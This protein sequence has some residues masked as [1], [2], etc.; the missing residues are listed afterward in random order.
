[1]NVQ[2]T[3]NWAAW[4]MEA[5][6]ARFEVKEAPMWTPGEGEVLVRNRAVAVN[7]VDIAVQTL[8]FFSFKYPTILGHDLA[9]EVVEVG[10]GVT[11]YKKGDRVLGQAIGMMTREN[12][13]DAFQL[14]TVVPENLVTGL[15]DELSFEEASVLPL[16][17]ATAAAG[18]FQDDFL[19]LQYP[20]VPA[21]RSKNE[22]VL[23][24]GGSS[25]VGSNAVQ[26]AVAAGYEVIS[27]ASPHNFEYVK[28]LGAA[29]V[30]DYKSPTIVEDLVKILK[31]KTFAGT[32]ECIG[33]DTATPVC[34][35]VVR[36]LNGVKFVALTRGDPSQY[37]D[38]PCKH[39]WAST[40]KDN[41]VGK[42]VCND[43]LPEALKKGTFLA[44]PKPSIVG[45]GL[46]EI[47]NAVSLYAKG[48]LSAKKLVV[49]L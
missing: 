14:F 5:K 4:Q 32:M 45:H 28:N 46:D 29:Q 1:M 42:A 6:A 36:Q 9:G 17:F 8:D 44:A 2:D 48:G 39:V 23:I 3:G 49:T 13:H 35:D 34:M 41:Q 10:P 30:L 33:G 12:K 11:L 7:P 37:P 27:T 19:K 20:T 21:Q 43:F 47:Q 38:I 18:L 25:S 15:P 22:T 26:L 31:N 40:I 24:W 16:G